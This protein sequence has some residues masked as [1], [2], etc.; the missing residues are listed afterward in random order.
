MG[1]FGSTV[2]GGGAIG[3]TGTFAAVVLDLV[4]TEEKAGRGAAE[5]CRSAI[6][7]VF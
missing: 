7:R 5:I 3:S 1:K 6:T 4:G 2:T